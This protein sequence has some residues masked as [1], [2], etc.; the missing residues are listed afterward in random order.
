MSPRQVDVEVE[1]VVVVCLRVLVVVLGVLVAV[2]LCCLLVCVVIVGLGGSKMMG[3]LIT[4]VSVNWTCTSPAM[5][6]AASWSL[7]A[8]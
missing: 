8:L 4:P 2:L 6:D 7:F 5:D 1:D 3:A